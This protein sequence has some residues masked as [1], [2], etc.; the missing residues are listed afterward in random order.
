[1][2]I[3]KYV[4]PE[5]PF[6]SEWHMAEPFDSYYH[7]LAIPPDEQPPNHYRLLGLKL[8]E[9]NAGVIDTSADRQMAHVRSFQTGDR[10][11]DSQRLLNELATARRV[12]L[13]PQKKSAYD[14]TVKSE[15]AARA[16]P[17]VASRPAASKPAAT[18]T[19]ARAVPLAP[20]PCACCRR[21]SS[22]IANF[23]DDQFNQP[24]KPRRRPVKR[25]SG[26]VLLLAAG[27]GVVILAVA[28]WLMIP[29]CWRSSGKR[30]RTAFGNW[31]AASS[32]GRKHRRCL[33]GAIAAGKADDEPKPDTHT[34]DSSPT[35]A[36]IG[37][38]AESPA[39]APSDSA[40]KPAVAAI[41]E[42]EPLSADQAPTPGR[43][44]VFRGRKIDLLKRIEPARDSVVG[45]LAVRQ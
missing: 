32:G 10:A 28:G 38:P 40:P 27:A 18:K 13:D 3:G 45:A 7:W 8:F 23:A 16:K 11:A 25:T 39:A 43:S 30:L 22:G 42:R 37:P 31:Y 5:L 4:G 20:L 29:C 34:S 17:N 15:L 44:A 6:T 1:M 2:R 9:A 26:G 14:S 19:L 21:S 12:L 24:G 36:T 35:A 41:G 33:A